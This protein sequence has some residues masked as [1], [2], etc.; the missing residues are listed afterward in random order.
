MLI[1]SVADIHSRPEHLTAILDTVNTHHPDLMIIAGDITQFN[2][3]DAVFRFLKNLDIPVLAVTGNT[4][5]RC[6]NRRL[7]T[8]AGC[9]NLDRKPVSLFGVPFIGASGA[10]LLPLCS[11]VSFREAKLLKGLAAH[12]TT[13]SVLVVHPPP[14][15]I[16]DAVGG[17]FAAGSHGLRRLILD[18]QPALVL[19]GH[20]HEARGLTTLGHSLIINCAMGR[21]CS[22][23]LVTLSPGSRPEAVMLI[24]SADSREPLAT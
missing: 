11:P 12:V 8:T 14:R 5:T 21:H 23:A 20:I 18:R 17:K 13:D 22:G 15:G 10:L 1:Y 9:V 24:T 2:R 19:C 4:D 7:N 3:P 16:L 6:V